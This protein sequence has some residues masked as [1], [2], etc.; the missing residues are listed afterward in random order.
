M[1]ELGLV[2]NKKKAHLVPCQAVTFLG[3]VFD[4]SGDVVRLFVP[5]SKVEGIV[6]DVTEVL[7]RVIE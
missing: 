7:N 2:I 6:N 3:H 4:T 1:E 5:D